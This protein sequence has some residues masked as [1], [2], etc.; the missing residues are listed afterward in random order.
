MKKKSLIAGIMS[1]CIIGTAA[2]VTTAASAAE[3]EYVYGDANLDGSVDMSDIVLIMQSLANPAKYGINGSE[4]THITSEGINH[5][6]VYE[7]GNGLTA[8]DALSIQRFL[9]GSINALPESYSTVQTT[10]TTA[11]IVTTTTTTTQP[12][13]TVPK[14][15]VNTKIRLNGTSVSVEGKYAVANGSGYAVALQE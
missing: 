2:A 11:P 8:S 7:R 5:A 15:E 12:I 13:V 4:T 1:A 10:T 3:V 9:L 6:D 14:E